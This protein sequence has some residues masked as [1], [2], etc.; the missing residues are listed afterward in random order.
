MPFPGPPPGSV[1][2]GFLLAA[3]H[4]SVGK[5][6]EYIKFSLTAQTYSERQSAEHSASAC[7]I[8]KESRGVAKTVSCRIASCPAGRIGRVW[9][10]RTKTSQLSAQESPAIPQPVSLLTAPATVLRQLP[11]ESEEDPLSCGPPWGLVPSLPPV[12]GR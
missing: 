8:D 5:E 2:S 9:P 3:A 12:A 11:L 10:T 6:E 1:I 7:L 4:G